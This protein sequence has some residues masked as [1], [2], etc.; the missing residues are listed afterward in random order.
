MEGCNFHFIS[1]FEKCSFD[2]SMNCEFIYWGTY[3]TFPILI[4]VGLNTQ[5]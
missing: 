3:G 5:E 1:D 4:V 2:V